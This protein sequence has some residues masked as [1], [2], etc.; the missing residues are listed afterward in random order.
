MPTRIRY[1][2]EQREEMK[3]KALAMLKGG[4]TK[5]A[6]AAEL[7]ITYKTLMR[8]LGDAGKAPKKKATR[9]GRVRYTPEQKQRLQ[10]RALAMIEGGI[11]KK[12][13]AK[14]LGIAYRTLM[15]LLEGVAEKSKKTASK[16][17]ASKKIAK[18]RRIRYT[19]EQK[20]TLKAKALK[21]LAKGKSRFASAKELGVSYPT[22]R[23]I[24]AGGKPSKKKAKKGPAR[25]RKTAANP[26]SK[27]VAMRDRILDVDKKM[28]ELAKEKAGLQKEVKAVY[29]QLGKELLN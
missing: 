5:Q 29:K 6:A 27:M 10:D 14:E 1:T 28:A 17:I 7:K 23:D 25:G 12:A 21:L 4:S 24:L 22:L 20:K 26:I 18:D 9:A 11:S 8:V 3:S 15:R 2:P 19:P 13:I 16:K